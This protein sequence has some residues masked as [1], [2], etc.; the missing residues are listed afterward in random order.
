LKKR[1]TAKK[2]LLSYLS[3]SLFI[4]RR[5]DPLAVGLSRP[6]ATRTTAHVQANESRPSQAISMNDKKK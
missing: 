1:L 2:L 4:A 6:R 5:L 3:F